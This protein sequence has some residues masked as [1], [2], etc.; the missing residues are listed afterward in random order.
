[1][2]YPHCKAC[3][4][5]MSEAEMGRKYVTH[6]EYIGLCTGCHVVSGIKDW[7][8]SKKEKLEEDNNT[9]EWEELLQLSFD[10]DKDAEESANAITQ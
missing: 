5:V 1:M 8:S 7:T 2:C 9:S 6:D 3:D 4:K 10:M